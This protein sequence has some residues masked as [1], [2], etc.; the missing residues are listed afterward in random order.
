MPA[1]VDVWSIYTSV[2]F[3]L[4][5]ACGRAPWSRCLE[6]PLGGLTTVRSW[7]V[8]TISYKHQNYL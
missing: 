8:Q 4:H 7:L 6:M 3:S 2:C 1:G 5:L